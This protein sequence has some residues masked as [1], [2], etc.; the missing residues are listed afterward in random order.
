MLEIIRHI[1]PDTISDEQ[2]RKIVQLLLSFI[3]TQQQEILSLKAEIQLLKNEI[4]RLKGEDG[5]PD[6][7][8]NIEQKDTNISS[9][10]KEKKR[11]IHKKKA[12]KINIPVDKTE[13]ITINKSELP[14][15]AIL[16]Y[17]DELITQD[18][19]FKRE[20][21]LYKVAVYYSASEKKTYRSKLPTG[22]SYFSDNLKSFIICQSK[23][24]DVTS[25]K[26]LIMLRSLGI[27]ISTGSLSNILLEFTD[28]AQSQKDLILKA[29]L[30]CTYTQTDITGDRFKGKNYYTH[31]ITN[32][33]FTTF[34]T[35]SGKSTLDVLAAYQGL[36]QTSQLGL[37]YNQETINLLKEAKISKSDMLA[38]KNNF[39]ENE[40]ITLEKFELLSREK[41]PDL[42]GKRNIFV[43]V[44][45][46][47]ALSY[48]H[49]QDKVPIANIVV[50]DNAPEYN[51]IAIKT[52]ALCWIHDARYY[53]KII[54]LV[55]YHQKKLD[56]YKHQYWQYY[57]KLLA[58]KDNP[59]K[60]LAEKLF[61][62]FDS[63]FVPDTSFLQL[64][65]CIERTRANKKEL[66][67][68]LEYPQV[69]LHN[70]F[71]ELGARRQVRKRDISL[72]T[73][74]PKG[75]IAKDAF[76]SITQTAIQL[77]VN[78]F[79]YVKE[80]ITYKKN[81]LSLDQIILQKIELNKS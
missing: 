75:T 47:F 73:I 56:D 59:S 71:A 80:L 32:D 25:Q 10:G 52:H 53:N 17:Y 46:A 29:G 58:Y 24:C 39:Q 45:T 68:V 54:A 5:K 66:L 4:N 15:D 34:T 23:V 60:E 22:K 77:G 13:V 30:S 2:S 69:P 37:L 44:K 3:E 31:I 67:T 38:L 50:S 26:I 48:Y 40:N 55:S 16:K 72:H 28:L 63:L 33:L 11:K 8:P 64:N 62:D 70:N 76:L 9:K 12:K 51:K 36:T 1:N 14:S 49:S 65:Q 7:K 61:N 6:I 57:N 81:E 27:E 35:L 42:V 18:V 78:V 74:V 19:V 43:R 41:I 21:I 79:E 20:N